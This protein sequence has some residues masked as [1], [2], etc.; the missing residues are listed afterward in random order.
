[1]SL[2]LRKDVGPRQEK[3]EAPAGHLGEVYSEDLSES[4]RLR[5]RLALW[6]AVLAGWGRGC[7][8]LSG[9]TPKAGLSLGGHLSAYLVYSSLTGSLPRPGQVVSLLP[10]S[11]LLLGAKHTD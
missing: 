10:L 8:A 5:W 2:A 6:W 11:L 9:S 4:F 3:R 7:G 1:M